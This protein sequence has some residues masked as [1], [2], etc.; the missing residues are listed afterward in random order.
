MGK[1]KQEHRRITYTL[2]SDYASAIEVTD[3]EVVTLALLSGHPTHVVQDWKEIEK[4]DTKHTEYKK[5]KDKFGCFC[6]KKQAKKKDLLPKSKQNWFQEF[7]SE[8]EWMFSPGDA[9][10]LPPYSELYFSPLCK[11]AK[12]WL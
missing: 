3:L 11:N 4:T 10:I 7:V 9:Q 12:R 8:N 1:K 2:I 6:P 5:L